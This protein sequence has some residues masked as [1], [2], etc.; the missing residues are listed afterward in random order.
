MLDSGGA[1]CSESQRLAGVRGCSTARAQYNHR[2]DHSLREGKGRWIFQRVCLFQTVLTCL[3]AVAAACLILE[4]IA[5]A[6][7][8]YFES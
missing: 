2:I 1:I 8:K 5:N 4:M 7:I 6:E 3:A